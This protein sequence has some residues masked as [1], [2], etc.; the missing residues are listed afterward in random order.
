M[1]PTKQEKPLSPPPTIKAIRDELKAGTPA[2]DAPT[3]VGPQVPA[4][5]LPAP[6]QPIMRHQAAT[7]VVSDVRLIAPSEG[8]AWGAA[9]SGSQTF[10]SSSGPIEMPKS[11]SGPARS[12]PSR[13]KHR[14][15]PTQAASLARPLDAC[16]TR[17]DH[18]MISFT[19]PA[20]HHPISLPL[21]QAGQKARC[22]Q[23][24]SAIRAPQL[25]TLG[26]AHSY[27]RSVESLLHPEHFSSH[28]RRQRRFLGMPWPKMHQLLLGAAAAI[29]AVCGFQLTRFRGTV[30][31]VN[32]GPQTITLET[33]L[34][35]D[36]FD[37]VAD[38]EKL[39]KAFL[40]AD[41]WQARARFVRDPIR[42]GKLLEQS[43]PGEFL[44]HPIPPVSVIASAP[45]YYYK[46]EQLKHRHS[47]VE[48]EMPDGLPHH[49]I[50]EFLPEGPKIEWES[51]VAY[52]PVSWQEMLA[53]ADPNTVY[54]QRVC[55]CLDDY[56]NHE[57]S[58]RSKYISLYLQ[59]A[60]TGASLGNGYLLR[61]SAA[62]VEVLAVLGPHNR[63]HLKRVMIEV[64]P[65]PTSPTNRLIEI[66]RFIKSG[67][68]SPEASTA[69]E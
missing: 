28:P 24:S 37:P 11:P 3:K 65:S 56:Y 48:V 5:V 66:T 23:C 33:K 20:C 50:V 15:R 47:L 25:H 69:V 59:D 57:F 32:L 16:P 26:Q 49:F 21:P 53:A 40:M 31:P 29:V 12:K 51:S 41:S 8:S 52:V 35:Q 27:E 45:T 43:Y 67:F 1:K 18:G 55:A 39:V 46:T 44:R 38:A 13:W 22:P 68:R 6:R 9:S 30:A 19:C 64:R 34:Q 62:A 36:V 61:D 14:L 2:A 4:I 63:Q 54:L 60:N 7:P 42:V 58:D 17:A 10:S